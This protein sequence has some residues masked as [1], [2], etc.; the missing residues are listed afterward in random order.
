MRTLLLQ[1][2]ISFY[3]AVPGHGELTI[4]M[5]LQARVRKKRW[6]YKSVGM[7][8]GRAIRM[9]TQKQQRKDE[10]AD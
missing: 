5:Y 8:E 3:D 4:K 7:A 2:N 10:Q 9:N 1:E 6:R